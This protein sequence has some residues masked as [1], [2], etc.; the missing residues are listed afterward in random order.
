ML[1]TIRHEAICRYDH[2]VSY[3]IQ[4]LRLTPRAE[5]NQRALDWRIRAPGRRRQQID[6]YGNVAHLL[7]L[8]QPHSE[9]TILISGSVETADQDAHILPEAGLLTPLAYLADTPLTHAD[10]ALRDFAFGRLSPGQDRFK[11]LR[12][13]MPAMCDI[14]RLDPAATSQ[15]D[16]ASVA[17]SRGQGGCEDRAHVFISC[18]RTAGIPARYVS[19]YYCNA[20][21]EEAAGHA[22]AD[23]WL[24]GDL[25]W[26]SFDVTRQ[27]L[28]AGEYCRL[29]V[30][31]DYL[32]A[33]P[34][35]GVR[36]AGWQDTM[37]KAVRVAAVEQQQQ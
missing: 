3:S 33:C 26:V 13:L 30:G 12:G 1:L 15:S 5:A 14:V 27:Q 32:D 21:R 8:D 18:C 16:G 9:I 6:A 25:G 2:T 35:R 29:A 17:F 24:G 19:G 28:A 11:A 10:D 36:R 34:V 31:R 37:T 23:A 20:G 7:T 22:W 4:H